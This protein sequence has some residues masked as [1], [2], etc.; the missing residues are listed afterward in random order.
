MPIVLADLAVAPLI[1]GAV[2]AGVAHWEATRPADPCQPPA[3]R[4]ES[5]NIAAL[6]GPNSPV[7]KQALKLRADEEKKKTEKVEKT[8]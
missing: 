4:I 2:A 1:A 7:C 8:P 6:P 3:I 5:A